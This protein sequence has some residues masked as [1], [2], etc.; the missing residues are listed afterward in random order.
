MRLSEINSKFTAP[1]SH[2]Y[3][4]T[5]ILDPMEV[6]RFHRMAEDRPEITVLGV[7]Q[8]MA[9][10]WTIFVACASRDGRDLLESNW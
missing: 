5:I 10:H 6:G 2:P 4:A 9:D 7:E 3:T 8:S 1:A